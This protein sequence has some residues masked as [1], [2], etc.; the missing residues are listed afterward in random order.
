[1]LYKQNENMECNEM[2]RILVDADGC[3]VSN[4]VGKVAEEI[5]IEVVFYCDMN[6]EMHV[7]YGQVI[8]ITPGVDAVDFAIISALKQGDIIITQDYGVA[9]MAL[10][11]KARAL[12]QNGK[13]Y[14]RD[15]IDQMLFERHLRK[16]ARRSGKRISG[17]EPH[18]RTPEMDRQFED[19]LRG[20]I[21]QLLG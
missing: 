20:V 1:M 15:N 5:G 19:K 3:P 13:E 16:K 7:S 10:G 21:A 11:K 18:K 12:H 17:K 4:I 2:F 8:R 14:T 9:A 6:H